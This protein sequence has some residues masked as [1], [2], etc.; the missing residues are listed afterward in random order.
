MFV[1][2]LKI[3]R[4]VDFGGAGLI[5]SEKGVGVSPSSTTRLF[6]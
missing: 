1:C 3:V 5:G 4:Y 2:A 6:T